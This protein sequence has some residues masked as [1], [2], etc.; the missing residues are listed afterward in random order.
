MARKMTEWPSKH[1]PITKIMPSDGCKGDTVSSREDGGAISTNLDVIWGMSAKMGEMIES[2]VGEAGGEV[3]AQR[4]T[5]YFAYFDDVISSIAAAGALQGS[6]FEKAATPRI[7][8]DVGD[9]QTEPTGELSGPPVARAASLV[10][11]AHS[12]Q[13][14]LSGEAQRVLATTNEG[15]WQVRAL[16]SHRLVGL[17][18]PESVYQLMV[19]GRTMEFPPLRT[20]AL[21]P[22]L[23]GTGRD[24]PGYELRDRVGSGAF[25]DV[26]RAYQATVGREVAVKVIKPELANQPNFVRRFEVEAQLVARLEHPHIVPLYDYWRDPDGAFLV[27]RW[28]RGG[29]LEDLLARGPVEPEVALRILQ[30]VG[31]A[32][33]TAH[34]SGVIHRDVKAANVLLD[35]DGNAY[36]TDFRIAQGLGEGTPVSVATDVADFGSLISDM[37]NGNAPAEI[38]GIIDRATAADPGNEFSSVVAT[39]TALQAALGTQAASIAREFTPT[40]NPYKGLAAFTEADAGDFHGRDNGIF[41]AWL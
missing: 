10:A 15:G 37:L 26:Y 6:G 28:I 39:V 21:P 9:V 25:G 24:L 12:G 23:P 41:L 29:S 36:L 16:G 33:E 1:R 8:V 20:D 5:A 11:A 3:F 4:G 32:L 22:R 19:E 2:A 13:V 34:R 40:R 35:E 7:A 17:D 30:Q 18:Q 14:L 38:K 27:M 31:D